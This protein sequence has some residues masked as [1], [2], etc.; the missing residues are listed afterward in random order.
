MATYKLVWLDVFT[1][2]PL[3][4][5]P[6]PVVFDETE[7][8]TD[9]QMLAVAREFNTSETTF[10]VPAR[11][12][13]AARRLR[14]FST[15]QEVFGAGHNALGAWWAILESGAIAGPDGENELWQEL[16]TRLLPL[17]AFRERGALRRIA[18]QQEP[19][20]A[21]TGAPDRRSLAEA[22]S[23]DAASL[24]VPGLEPQVVST[25]ARHLLVP[26]RT[27]ADVAKARVRPELLVDLARPFGCHGCYLFCRESVEGDAVA[28]ARAFGPGIGIAED[29]ATG[30]AAGPLIAYLA[31]RQLVQEREWVMVEQGYELGR[32][33]RIEVRVAGERVEIAGECVI[34]ARGELVV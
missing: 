26:A 24:D 23:L 1:A 29:P 34:V 31:S 27:L 11:D 30:S 13:K 25:G 3:G 33:S 28:H 17:T 20:E 16:G 7:A 19:P 32:P 15:K 18:M 5:N 21:G 8:L 22:L 4:G 9:E 14:C 6:L 10:V 2:R 12:P